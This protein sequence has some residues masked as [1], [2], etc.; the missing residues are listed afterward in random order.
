M[1]AHVRP[2]LHNKRNH[3]NEKL[4]HRNQRAAPDPRVAVKTQHG[5]NIYINKIYKNKRQLTVPQ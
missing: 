4:S 3:R 2:V 5:Q 1:G